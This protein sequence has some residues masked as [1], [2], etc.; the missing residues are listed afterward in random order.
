MMVFFFQ[1]YTVFWRKWNTIKNRKLEFNLDF[2]TIIF[3]LF[4]PGTYV[5]EFWL[6]LKILKII[7]N[8]FVFRTHSGRL[9][10]NFFFERLDHLSCREKNLR[11]DQT[12]DKNINTIALIWIGNVIMWCILLVNDG[13]RMI[14]CHKKVKKTK[15]FP[16][17]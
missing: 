5:Y 1:S 4:S 8:W 10:E 3:V 9:E 12:K 2:N 17:R 13:G 14:F 16:K 15:I 11:S 7:V 6:A